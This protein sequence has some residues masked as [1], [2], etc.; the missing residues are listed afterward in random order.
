ML[1]GLAVLVFF[2]GLVDAYSW[3]LGILGGIALSVVGVTLRVYAFTRDEEFG[4]YE[5]RM[6]YEH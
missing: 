5:P 4:A 1:Y 2:A 6:L 3:K